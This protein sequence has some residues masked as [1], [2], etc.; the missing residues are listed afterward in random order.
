MVEIDCEP[1]RFLSEFFKEF[2]SP[3]IVPKKELEEIS[4]V[5]IGRKSVGKSVMRSKYLGQNEKL[6]PTI[7]ICASANTEAGF[8]YTE[9]PTIGSVYGRKKTVS[10]FDIGSSY[11]E[12]LFP[13]YCSLENLRIMIV[14]DNGDVV[15][16]ERLVKYVRKHT[17]APIHIVRTGSE[18]ID[19]N[20]P[21]TFLNPGWRSNFQ[22]IREYVEKN[23]LPLHTI[24]EFCQRD[25]N[26]AFLDIAK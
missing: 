13:L 10:I 5:M 26:R 22:D 14:I 24:F 11:M 18:N 21:P 25:I 12:S 2:F 15:D 17:M 20:I 4:I 6:S 9:N 19:P 23:G 3:S 1:P 8:R 16:L 7:S